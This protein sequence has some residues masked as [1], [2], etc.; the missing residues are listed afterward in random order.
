MAGNAPGFGDL[1]S[2]L[3]QPPGKIGW[4]RLCLLLDEAYRAHPEEVAQLWVP[5]AQ[6]ALASWPAPV[7]VCPTQWFVPLEL[8]HTVPMLTLVRA[9]DWSNAALSYK[10]ISTLTQCP[11]LAHLESLDLSFNHIEDDALVMILGDASWH[12]SLRQLK[13]AS[14]G[15]TEASLTLALTRFRCDALRVLDLSGNWMIADALGLLLA[16]ECLAR[17]D[18]LILKHFSGHWGDWLRMKATQ[19]PRLS[20]D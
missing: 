9:L 4:V 15:I 5:H 18:S 1:R 7:R 16:S 17:L 2:L 8:G 14:C 12:R 11:E 10:T 6:R 20:C 13:V 3:A 19:D